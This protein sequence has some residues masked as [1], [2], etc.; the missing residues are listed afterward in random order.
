MKITITYDNE[1]SKPDLRSD[2]G[3]S[4]LAEAFGSSFLFDT[5]ARG[6]ILLGNMKKLDIDPR[7]I[8]EI[9]ISHDHWDHTGGYLISLG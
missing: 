9:M 6:S 8:E 2:W 3:F 4:C 5:G 1:A 7:M